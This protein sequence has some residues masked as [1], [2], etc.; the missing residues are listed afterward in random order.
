MIEDTIERWHEIARSKK[1]ELLNELL[2][3]DATLISPVVHSPQVG[4]EITQKYLTAAMYVFGNESFKYVRE[5]KGENAAVLEFETEI[6]GK[7]VNGVDMIAWNDAGL[8]TEFRV[9]VRPLQAVNLIHE[10]MGQML[11]SAT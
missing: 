4:M 3:E 11:K 10:M 6:D 8:I 7:Y 2:A 1:P 5:F 9:M